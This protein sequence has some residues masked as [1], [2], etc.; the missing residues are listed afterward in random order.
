[1]ASPLEGAATAVVTTRLR[2]YTASPT[3][4]PRFH[5]FNPIAPPATCSATETTR[6]KSRNEES[7]EEDDGFQSVAGSA[8]A[9][10]VCRKFRKQRI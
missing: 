9:T 8:N 5:R 2:Q 10:D 4:V 3:A 6:R 1:M 7:D